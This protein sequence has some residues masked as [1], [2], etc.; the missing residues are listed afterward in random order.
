MVKFV[1]EKRIKKDEALASFLIPKQ[2][3]KK[4]IIK[5][6]ALP[7]LILSTL[8]IG[9]CYSADIS[10]INQTATLT[11]QFTEPVEMP[12]ELVET[13]PVQE[14]TPTDVVQESQ[15]T[16]IG[17]T[18]QPVAEATPD[19]RLDPED[20]RNWPVV[21]TISANALEIY[22]TGLALGNDPTHFSKVGDCQNVV[23]LFLADFDKGRYQLGEEY[24]ALQETIDYYEGSWE[25]GIDGG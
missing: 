10:Q 1:Y 20:W 23:S 15:P 7:L 13:V 5:L 25:R 14:T 22:E 4:T 8:L 16:E 18:P 11:A 12:S 6:H 19:L 3:M 9:A 21:P 24:G 2:P 17:T